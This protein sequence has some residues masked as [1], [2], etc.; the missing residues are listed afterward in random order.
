MKTH[1]IAEVSRNSYGDEI[2]N[3]NLCIN[4]YPDLIGISLIFIEQ[5]LDREESQL[6]LISGQLVVR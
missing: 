6:E 3:T 2:A 4:K 1:N 5:L